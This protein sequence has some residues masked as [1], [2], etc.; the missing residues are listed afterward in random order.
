M[1]KTIWICSRKKLS[2]KVE[3]QIYEI[4]KNISPDN[5]VTAEPKVIISDNIAFGVMNPKNSLLYNGNSLLLGVITTNI[6]NW[7]VPL[8]D[9]PD[10]SYAL[11]RDGEQYCEIVS[12]PAGSRTIWY[13]RND[14]IFV[15]STSQIALIKFIGGFE[16][17]E[18]VVPWILSSGS[19][20]P[21]HSWDKRIKRIPPDSSVVLNK[22]DWSLNTKTNKIEFKECKDSNKH[23]EQKL[24]TV[25]NSSIESMNLNYSDWVL[26]VSGG[27]DSRGILCLLKSNNNKKNLKTITW[28]LKSSL[29]DFKN[30][31]FVA[32]KLAKELNVP[33]KYYH[34]DL[35]KEPVEKIIDR[36]IRNGEG[37]VDHI[38]GYL[39]GFKIWE[40]LHNENIQGIIRG[41][42]GFGWSNVSSHLTTRLSVGLGL[43]SDYSN[44]K[45][46][47]KMGFIEQKVPKHL[48]QSP[49]ESLEQWRDRLYHEYRLP[50]IMA[51]LS[52]LKFSYVEQVNPLLFRKILELVR[53]QPDRL[54]TEKSL[55][56]KIVVS[57]SPKI[58]F[59]TGGA[60]GSIVDF[61]KQKQVVDLLKQEITNNLENEIIPK[62]FLIDVLANL[63]IVDSSLSKSKSF[64]L[65]P[66]I[67]L[68]LPSYFKNLLK[69][70]V[71]SLNI[72]DYNQLAFRIFIIL[73]MINILKTK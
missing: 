34:T 16:F 27:Y 39:D 58:P 23:H 49:S 26:P 20:G 69:D 22:H 61:L 51:A 50:T 36:F 66:L 17:D 40:T 46:L 21:T 73:R 12:D 33:H 64:S 48:E 29:N 45:S 38:S 1:A 70:N 60:N 55:F 7:H 13:Y 8:R 25:L 56:K 18:R 47:I 44:L 42:E 31:A 41:D 24:R 62:D 68:I 11:F 5:I 28:G 43:C 6:D 54:R 63:K 57:L 32:Q 37:R 15:A 67:K 35:S 10:G 2:N 14:E 59:A 52:D 4:C 9:F 3:Q 71:S 53:E 30:D 65:K 72:V 19:L